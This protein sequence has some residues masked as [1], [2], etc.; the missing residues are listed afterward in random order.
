MIYFW[1]IVAAVLL[2]AVLSAAEMAFIAANRVRM[3]HLAE[4]GDP[5]AARYL[6]AFRHPEHVLS[7]AMIGVTVAHIA[8]SSLATWALL[9]VA[10]GWAAFVATVALVP[11]MLIFGGALGLGAFFVGLIARNLIERLR[12]RHLE[13]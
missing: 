10:G 8:A 1:A 12:K 3:R 6:E 2:T 5:V 13:I 7:A 11:V 4:S 9:P